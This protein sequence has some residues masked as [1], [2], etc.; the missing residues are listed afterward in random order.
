M[1][2]VK[3]VARL[4]SA[5]GLDIKDAIR[6]DFSILFKPHVQKLNQAA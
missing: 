4:R 3:Y 6:D 2:R 5:I 1:K